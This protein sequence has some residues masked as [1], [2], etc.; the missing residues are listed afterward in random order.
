MSILRDPSA[1]VIRFAQLEFALTGDLSDNQSIMDLNG[2]SFSEF[3]L[4]D[5]KFFNDISGIPYDLS[6]DSWR[7]F[8]YGGIT[9]IKK[10]F[11]Q[12][13]YPK[14][15]LWGISGEIVFIKGTN[16]GDI[17]Q[18]T[19]FVTNF[20]EDLKSHIFTD[21]NINKIQ[22]LAT[23]SHVFLLNTFSKVKTINDLMTTNNSVLKRNFRSLDL[24]EVSLLLAQRYDVVN[25]STTAI[26][27]YNN[28]VQI[29]EKFNAVVNLFDT[30]T[31][32]SDYRKKVAYLC[33]SVLFNTKEST[34]KPIEC[35]FYFRCS[36]N[37]S[38]TLSNFLTENS[39]S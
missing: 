28:A 11:N 19:T 8:W 2:I 35:L 25:N 7:D 5:Q 31:N 32:P 21:L 36:K 38:N 13:I 18:N 14:L 6:I 15:K 26:T 1:V 9:D 30:S 37:S 27:A 39:I 3:C 23:N 10:P 33:F 16:P 22:D 24:E 20:Y 34:I 12:S 4:D 29:Y 17:S